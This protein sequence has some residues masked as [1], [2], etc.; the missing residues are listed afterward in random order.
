VPDPDD[1]VDLFTS[2]TSG[3]ISRDDLIGQLHTFSEGQGGILGL[4]EGMDQGDTGSRTGMSEQA[5]DV[6]GNQGG[7]VGTT[8]PVMP[9]G[10]MPG[11]GL[12][13]G[14]VGAQGGQGALGQSAGLGAIPALTE[15]LDQR[16]QRISMFLQGFGLKPNDADEMS[17]RLNP[18]SEEEQMWVG[19]GGG[20]ET[21]EERRKRRRLAGLGEETGSVGGEAAKKLGSEWDYQAGAYK[22]IAHQDALKIQEELRQSQGG[23][24]DVG[25]GEGSGL[26]DSSAGETLQTFGSQEEIDV[27][28]KFVYE[29]DPVP[30][31]MPGAVED[32][33]PAIETEYERNLRLQMEQQELDAKKEARR[34]ETEKYALMESE[35]IAN[36]RSFHA[37]FGGSLD[38]REQGLA[39]QDEEGTWFPDQSALDEYNVFLKK[40]GTYWNGEQIGFGGMDSEGKPQPEAY[41][42]LRMPDGSMPKF[43]SKADR[44]KLNETGQWPDGT[45]VEG[46]PKVK[47]KDKEPTDKPGTKKN[48]DGS[49]TTTDIGDDGYITIT[50]TDSD[51]EVIST[52]TL[53]PGGVT[54]DVID[55]TGGSSGGGADGGADG[56]DIY[57]SQDFLYGKKLFDPASVDSSEYPDLAQLVQSLTEGGVRSEGITGTV[58]NAVK[59]METIKAQEGENALQRTQ[60]FFI[61]QLDRQAVTDRATL[62][63][64]LAEGV[65][66]GEVAE[67]ATLA[68]EMEKNAQL[69]REY[70]LSGMMPAAWQ[71]EIGGVATLARE[72]M[73]IRETEA[74]AAV[75]GAEAAV[76]AAEASKLSVEN[77]REQDLSALFGQYIS[78]SIQ[79]AANALTLDA[80]KWGWTKKMQEAELTGIFP[81][82]IETMSAKRLSFEKDV[83]SQKNIWE[84]RR[85]D[86][87]ELSITN[88]QQINSYSISSNASI[89]AGRLSEAVASRKAKYKAEANKLQ[90]D[91]EKL[92]VE[93][94]LSL[95]EPATFL[96]ATRFGLLDNLGIA[97]GVDFS[98]EMYPGEIPFM[99]EPGT[100]PTM[101]QLRAATPAE[102]QLMLAE[103]ASSGGYSVEEALSRVQA[104]MPGGRTIRRESIA[105]RAR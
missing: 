105:G 81:G 92:K 32:K 24:F 73:G 23:A 5:V 59:E 12:E 64:A 91:K 13:V 42:L 101:Q 30:A 83:S 50:K 90:L 55:P 84:T 2:Y 45:W 67:T 99:L 62:D 85:L 86:N 68:A 87:E 65:A 74:G 43:K 35:K 39:V 29:R 34:L 40:V 82:E 102:R 9:G 66:I 63:R 16:H 14:G 98:D 54:P 10:V 41:W 103:M 72:E 31:D 75:T 77:R 3:Q 19:A 89:E 47:P 95:S 20:M 57:T 78:P 44:D 4:L 61:A 94:L 8:Q 27:L 1:L 36:T 26:V 17:M 69:M 96:F 60:S 79:P 33:L 97:L 52:E 100:I 93:T 53:P 80:Q 28:P 48:A 49:T 18:W 22:D 37:M 56:T 70:Q 46:Y 51:G 71:A 76:T 88:Q 58:I 7:A 38:I 21:E 15:P 6:V 25:Q 104:G 11:V